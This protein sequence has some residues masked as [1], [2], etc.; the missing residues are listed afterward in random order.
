[1]RRAGS[2]AAS[3]IATQL[4]Q[5]AGWSTRR[6]MTYDMNH[7]TN[8]VREIQFNT[9]QKTPQTGLVVTFDTNSTGG[10][11]PQRKLPVGGRSARWALAE[12]YGVQDG[13]N[14]RPLEWRGPVYE[15]FQIDQDKIIISFKDGTDRGLLLDQDIDVGFYIAG[16]DHTFHHAHAR[17]IK[18]NQ[19]Q[20]WSDEVPKPVAVRYGWSN[21][22]MGGLM[23][24]RELPAYPFRTDKWPLTPHQSTGSY[25][26][27]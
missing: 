21:L 23:N 26:A 24:F 16:D 22:P 10:I 18:D 3:R 25:L 12:V 5:I 7:H 27:K 11:H 6:S 19:L 17:I 2:A 20:V 8:I 15:S 9:W 14:K 1:M 13:R 4:L